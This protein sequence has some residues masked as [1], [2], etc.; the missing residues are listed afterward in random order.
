MST[1]QIYL[2][3]FMYGLYLYMSSNNYI[4]FYTLNLEYNRS[5]QYIQSY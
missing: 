1:F 3:K 5:F 4:V 2:N